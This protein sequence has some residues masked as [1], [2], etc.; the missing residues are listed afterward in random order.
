VFFF[1]DQHLGRN[2]ARRLGIPVEEM[3]LWDTYRPPNAE[4]IRRAKVILWPG[5]CNVHQRFRPEHVHAVR[6]RLPDVRVIVH[7]ESPMEVVDLADDAGSTAHIIAQVEA[8]PPGASWAIGTEARLV[9]R[10]QALHPEQQIVSL[11]EVPPFC[12][13]MCQITPESLAEL[14]EA[15]VSGRLVNQVT[16]DAET[17]RRARV[18]LERMLAV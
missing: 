5:S 3:L 18:A 8:A 16:V 6:K 9:H 13:T 4:A 7:P 11:A 17:A 1:P 14:L 2:T 10:L 12:R 15:L